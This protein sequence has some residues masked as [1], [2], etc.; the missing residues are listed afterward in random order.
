MLKENGNLIHAETLQH[1]YPHCWRH[2]TPLIFRATEQWFI[3]MDDYNYGR[4][5]VYELLAED[6]I[7][8]VNWF[9]AQGKNSI[10]SMVEQR[11]DWCISR[12]RL[13]GLPIALFVHKETGKV[14]P[15]MSRLINDVIAPNI[16]KKGLIYWHNVDA[17]NFLKEHAKEC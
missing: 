12:Q 5:R 1:S 15:E 11:P 6:A 16:E 10:K 2:K 8:K 7:E 13:W 14:H 17:N 4:K 9:P 3:S